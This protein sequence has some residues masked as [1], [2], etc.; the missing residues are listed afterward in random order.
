MTSLVDRLKPL[1][2]IHN[3]RL[4]TGEEWDMVKIKDLL[5]NDNTSGFTPMQ[6]VELLLI[7]D[8]I[9]LAEWLWKNTSGQKKE[10]VSM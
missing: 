7:N 8:D 1:Q 10:N 6:K 3:W 9:Q 5:V 2:I 4:L